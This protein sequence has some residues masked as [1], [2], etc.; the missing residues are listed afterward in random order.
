VGAP[1]GELTK[2]VFA[3]SRHGR[4]PSHRAPRIGRTAQPQDAGESKRTPESSTSQKTPREVLVMRRLSIFVALLLVG[5]SARS[6]APTVAPISPQIYQKHVN[7]YGWVVTPI[8]PIDGYS[9]LPGSLA[10][11]NQHKMWVAAEPNGNDPNGGGELVKILMNGHQ[12]RY[13]LSILPGGL[14]YGPDGNMWVSGFDKTSGASVVARVTLSGQET[15]YPINLPTGLQVGGLILG[16]DGAF[17]FNTCNNAGT[18]GGVGR[19][20]TSGN[21]TFYPGPCAA[22]IASGPDAN[23]WFGDAGQNIYK[24]NTQG[25][26]LATYPV[27]EQFFNDLKAGTDGALYVA[28]IDNFNNTP[29]LIRVTTAGVITKIGHD[30]YGDGFLSIVSGPD[31]NL[32]ISGAHSASSDLIQY[33][34]TSQS[35]G[36]RVRGPDNAGF[37][38]A[39]GPDGNIWTSA[40]YSSDVDTYV[41]Q[42][43]TVTPKTLTLS[44]GKSATLTAG[45]AN[46]AGTWTATSTKPSIATVT[47]NSNNGKFTVKGVSAGTAFVAV[48]DSMYNSVEVKVTVQ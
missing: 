20:D 45:E 11:D 27:G 44:V 6:V 43:M 28:A 23:I 33:N 4:F 7:K 40:P 16:S 31:G 3:A 38:L 36:Q 39:D 9:V 12:S 18:G 1:A 37:G 14:V 25:M 22:V 13:P 8:S 42:L 29:D 26:V 41:I 48:Y 24:M 17:W 30:N 34:V 15:D 2:P 21:V 32:W 19:I 35:F 46:Y 5:C 47:A 10:V